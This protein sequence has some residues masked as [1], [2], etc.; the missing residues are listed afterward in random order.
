M[1]ITLKKN[2][3]FSRVFKTGKKQYGKFLS[4]YYK[5]NP[6]PFNRYGF[7]SLRHFGNS[8]KRNRMRRLLR[9]SARAL[10]AEM[11]TG[12]DIIFMGCRLEKETSG[13]EIQTEMRTLL[14]KAGLMQQAGDS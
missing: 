5:K 9:E 2:Y 14:E 7:T 11:K 1:L 8:V 4:L 10:E 13:T 3:E 6:L 12:Y